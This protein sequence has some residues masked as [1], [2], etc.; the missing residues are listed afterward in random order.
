MRA[1][2]MTAEKKG[3]QPWA[4]T[5]C[6]LPIDANDTTSTVYDHSWNWKDFSCTNCSFQT[7][8][9]GKRV[10]SISS[11][12]IQRPAVFVSPIYTINIWAYGF[13]TL[14]S[15]IYISSSRWHWVEIYSNTLT[16]FDNKKVYNEWWTRI[17]NARYNMCCTINNSWNQKV[18]I[19]GVEVA[20]SSNNPSVLNIWSTTTYLW[21]SKWSQAATS[22]IIW[23]VILESGNR[24]AQEVLDYYNLTKRDYWIS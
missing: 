24:T 13:G 4:N 8:S 3:W 6:Y 2:L 5:L 22:W 17:T 9:S 10:L 7:L 20:S 14:F 21:Y 11:G 19:N 18:Y 15:Q 16:L 23:A 12:Y 1:L